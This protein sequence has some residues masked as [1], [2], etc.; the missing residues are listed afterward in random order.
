M[1]KIHDL[2][3]VYAQVMFDKYVNSNRFSEGKVE[4]NL[5]TLKG[6]YELAHNQLQC[7]EQSKND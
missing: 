7:L 6:F 2:A 1:D 4:G 5:I 3:L